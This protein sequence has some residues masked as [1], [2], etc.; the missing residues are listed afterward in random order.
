MRT[1]S[2]LVRKRKSRR[3]ITINGLNHGTQ[4]W[5]WQSFGSFISLDL[6]VA[7][8]RLLHTTE[9][10]NNLPIP[11][12]LAG[13]GC[14]CKAPFEAQRPHGHFGEAL[15]SSLN[16]EHTSNRP[17][18]VCSSLYFF[19]L[20]CTATWQLYFTDVALAPGPVTAELRLYSQ[21]SLNTFLLSSNSLPS[22]LKH[23][24]SVQDPT[25]SA[26]AATTTTR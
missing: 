8:R 25:A 22:F 3:R 11:Y 17:Q 13:L 6:Q 5:K 21:I 7:E 4:T 15:K 23:H 16:S 9:Q 12:C 2:V 10:P 26:A 1:H 14:V 18:I 19:T 20:P 24:G